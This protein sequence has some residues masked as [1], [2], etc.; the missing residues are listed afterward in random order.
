[1]IAG[2][3]AFAAGHIPPSARSSLEKAIAHIRY[4]VQVAE[5]LD[6]IDRWI[7]TAQRPE[8]VASSAAMHAR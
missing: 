4:N 1:M 7:A 6:D 5:H 8:A 3:N 2:L